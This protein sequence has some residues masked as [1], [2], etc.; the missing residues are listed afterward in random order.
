MGKSEIERMRKNPFFSVNEERWK[1]PK[2]GGKLF[3]VEESVFKT[4]DGNT[5]FHCEERDD[6]TFWNNPRGKRD[7][8][9]FNERATESDFTFSEEYELKDS[10][11]E[12]RSNEE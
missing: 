2:C 11:W 7:T 3:S 6:H 10:V 5:V 4:L 1:C 8:L 12:K 9:Y